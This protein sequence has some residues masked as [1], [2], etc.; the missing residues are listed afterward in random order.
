MGQ[1]IFW[2]GRIYDTNSLENLI[3]FNE[4]P[5]EQHKEISRRGGI[6]SGEKRRKKSALVKLCKMQLEKTFLAEGITKQEL[7]DFRRWQQEQRKQERRSKRD[8]TKRKSLI[9]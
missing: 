7:E 6:A 9:D 4:M 8:L 1:K 3:P 5:K 2:H